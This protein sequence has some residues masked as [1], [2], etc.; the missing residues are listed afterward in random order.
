MQN[1]TGKVVLITG[2]AGYLTAPVSKCFAAHGACVVIADRYLD[3]AE[4]LCAEISAESGTDA[5]AV[6]YEAGENAAAAAVVTQAVEQAGGLD[7]LVSAAYGTSTKL[8]DDITPEDLDNSN[9]LNITSSFL[10]AREAANAMPAEGGS[11]VLFS[12]MYG[13]IAPQPHIYPD[14][15]RPNCLD[16]G[17]G[18]AGLNAVVRYLAVHYAE[19]GIRVNGV[20]PGSFPFRAIS[21]QGADSEAYE[22]FMVNLARKAPMNRI[23]RRDELAGPVTFLA[24]EDASYITGQILAV[25][26]GVT[27]W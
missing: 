5:Y 7:I 27:A 13:T 17:A 1:F 11:M 18:K 15:I 4:K 21:S 6:Q 24:S 10:L 20:A 14:P 23:G 3:A 22:Q 26:G 12:S 19:R 9:H 8:L 2:G 16:Y 25:D